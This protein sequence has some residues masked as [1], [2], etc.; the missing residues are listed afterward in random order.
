LV[1]D[2][3]QRTQPKFFRE[4]YVKYESRDRSLSR[5]LVCHCSVGCVMSRRQFNWLRIQNIIACRLSRI[6]ALKLAGEF[7]A[8][9]GYNVAFAVM[10]KRK[11]RNLHSRFVSSP[12]RCGMQGRE[13]DFEHQLM[14][15]HVLPGTKSQNCSSIRKG[16]RD[17][18]RVDRVQRDGFEW[19]QR[20][21]VQVSQGEIAFSVVKITDMWALDF[22]HNL[23]EVTVERGRCWRIGNFVMG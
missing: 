8:D 16:R 6:H 12:I 1:P 22:Y 11:Q 18:M 10:K 17:R 19:L 5:L 20:L 2:Q 7:T 23:P 9:L 14:F 21:A 13:G 15:N 3:L 4:A